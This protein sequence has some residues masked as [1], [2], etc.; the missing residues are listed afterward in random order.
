MFTIKRSENNPLLSPRREHQWEA[1]ATFNWCPVKDKKLVH[2]VYRALSE[3]E[4]LEEPKIHHSI[5]GR[6]TTKNGIDFTD[7]EPF[8]FPEKDFEKYGC[9]DPRITKLGDTYYTFYTAL[10]TYP[11]S[12][13]GIKI[14]V[15]LSKDLKK[16]TAKHLVTPFNAKAMAL[17]PKKIKGKYAALLTIDTDRPPSNIAIALFDKIEDMWSGTYW[18]KWLKDKE[19]HF[20]NFHRA[21]DDQVELGAPPV[22]TKDGWLVIYSHI[23]HYTDDRRSFGIEAVLLDKKDPQLIIGRT[24]GSFL[25]PELFYEQTGMV[26]NI[27]FPSG[28][29]IQ[30]ED[31]H[32]YYGAADTHCA[33][34]SIHLDDLLRSMQPEAHKFVT[35]FAGNPIITPRK[36]KDW[37]AHGTFNPAAIELKNVIHILYRA[38]SQDDTSTIGHA[39]T[40]DGFVISKR[41]DK[42]IY[43]PRADFENKYHPGNSGCEDPRIVEIDGILYMT[44][45]AYDGSM[46]RV[47]LSSISSQDFIAGRWDKWSMPVIITPPDV[48]NKD[49]CIIPE[50]TKMGYVF[51]HRINESVCADLLQSLDFKNE[52]VEKC[53][54]VLYPRR[55]M[56]DGN[57]VGISGPPIKT[58]A[59]WL[60]FYHGV[61]ETGTYRVGAVL[62]DLNEPTVVLSRTAVPLFEPQEDYEIKGVV[63][64]VVFPCGQVKRKDKIFI[65]YGGGDDIVGVATMSLSKLLKILT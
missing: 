39:T 54:E 15:A 35:R 12:A 32:I 61:S 59:G 45:T 14:A 21:T 19:S 47:A 24:K 43:V 10:S 53:I 3:R 20:I 13:E 1:A 25:V 18:D 56:W 34:A 60:L 22:E 38:M 4:Q 23:N 62:L 44:Y 16:V 30:G 65:Y 40:K 55:G 57:K 42:P 28:A 26:P 48:P 41:D 5:I 46:P 51:L 27:V 50:K 63:P 31:L 17:F 6:A 52:R 2:V 8:I 37:E 29:L 33:R 49:A 9:E 36:T 64:K 7:R 11:F 58:R